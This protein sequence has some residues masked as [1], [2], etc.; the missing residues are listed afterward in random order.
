[1][2]Y[3][4][5]GPQINLNFA[6]GKRNTWRIRS[7]AFL[8]KSR[9]F[10][11]HFQFPISCLLVFTLLLLPLRKCHSSLQKKLGLENS[12]QNSCQKFFMHLDIATSFM[13]TYA[14]AFSWQNTK[15]LIFWVELY[16][17]MKRSVFPLCQK[18]VL[19]Q[20]VIY[21]FI[22]LAFQGKYL[23]LT[24]YLK[25]VKKESRYEIISRFIASN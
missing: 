8:A 20:Q 3:F 19:V 14:L 11:G 23:L 10:G 18:A 4:I 24:Q 25:E 15:V 12:R 9:F 22:L 21:Q 6:L 16:Y 13:L 1:M 5:S 7:F 2:P 17:F